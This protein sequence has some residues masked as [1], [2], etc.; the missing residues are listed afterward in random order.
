MYQICHHLPSTTQDRQSILP[1]CH[2]FVHAACWLFDRSIRCRVSALIHTGSDWRLNTNNLLYSRAGRRPL[3]LVG[4]SCLFVIDMAA[5]GLAFDGSVGARK[6]VAA[7]GFIFN[8]EF[9]YL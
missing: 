4:F 9:L 6:G 5:G 3:A 2:R 1:R 7:L 8:C